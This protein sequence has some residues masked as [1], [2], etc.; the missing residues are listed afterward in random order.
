MACLK[1]VPMNEEGKPNLHFHLI[2]ELL[3][4]TVL[5]LHTIQIGVRLYVLWIDA[6]FWHKPLSG[7]A[8]DNSGMNPTGL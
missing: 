1:T 6:S 8:Y 4:V 5:F 3:V 7:N 2:W